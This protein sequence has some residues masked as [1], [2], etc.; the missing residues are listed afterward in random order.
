MRAD[1]SALD[2]IIDAEIADRRAHPSGD[3]LDVLE[4]LVADGSLS[5]AEIR[6][7]VATLIGAGYDT[8]SASLAWIH[9]DSMELTLILARLAQRLDLTSVSSEVPAPVG[10][11]V[12]RSSGGV[13]MQ[14]KR[15][16]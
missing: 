11:V 6:D 9:C 14:V 12:N 5:D 1:R 7:Q 13:P 3:P 16:S 10:M 15:R 8:T 2:Q 4:T